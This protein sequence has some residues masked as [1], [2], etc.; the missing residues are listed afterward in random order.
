MPPVPDRLYFAYGSNLSHQQMLTERCP[1]ALPLRRSVLAD[2]RLEFVGERTER[3]GEGGVATVVPAAGS[4]VPGALYLINAEHE[5]S[6]DKYEGV[7]DGL[8]AKRMRD[9]AGELQSALVYIATPLAGTCN[10]P[11]QK[12]LQR[13]LE[14][15]ADWG[16]DTRPLLIAAGAEGA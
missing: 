12:Y 15:Y 1:G 10:P 11:G 4:S 2:H 3:W 14:G 6:L 7:A 5:A 13:I 9:P 8:Y 16:L